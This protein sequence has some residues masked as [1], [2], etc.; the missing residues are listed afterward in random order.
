MEKF[1]VRESRRP[2]SW[3]YDDDT[4]QYVRRED[5]GRMHAFIDAAYLPDPYI[6]TDRLQAASKKGANTTGRLS[7]DPVTYALWEHRK[8]LN[9]CRV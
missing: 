3:F 9:Q 8:G 1:V 6:L 5:D 2:L 4:K 7:A